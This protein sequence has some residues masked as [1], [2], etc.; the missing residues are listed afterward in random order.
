MQFAPY[1][2]HQKF[3]GFLFYG[4][5][6]NHWTALRQLS[7]EHAVCVMVHGKSLDCNIV[8]ASRETSIVGRF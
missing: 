6:L 4:P 8:T 3:D 5:Q 1:T 7:V 2:I